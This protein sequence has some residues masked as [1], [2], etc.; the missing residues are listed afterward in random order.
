MRTKILLL[1]VLAL[2]INILA[3]NPTIVETF[4][5]K[6]SLDWQEYADKKASALIQNG[7]LELQC[8]EKGKAATVQVELPISVEHDFKLYSKIMVHKINDEN[9]F[10]IIIDMDENFNKCL[11]LLKESLFSCHIYN[12]GKMVSGDERPIKL[13]GGKN[14]VV[15][16]ILERRGNKYIFYMNNMKIYEFRR[17]LTSPVFGFYTENESSISIDEFKMEQEYS[18]TDN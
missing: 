15:D 4:D 10:G 3:Q 6:V 2:P 17:N 18:G 1:F 7:F 13:K 8:K 5:D 16:I 9:R 14:Q 11:F 12:D